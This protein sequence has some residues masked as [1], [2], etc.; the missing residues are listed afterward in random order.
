M[1]RLIL[2][3]LD[4]TVT[5]SGPGIKKSAAIALEAQGIRNYTDEQLDL[6]VGPPL[7]ESFTQTFG[8]TDEQASQAILD[9]RAYYEVK[10]KF[11]NSV[12]DGI[13]VLLKK[14]RESGI[15]C[16]IASSK[17]E[18]FVI[19]ILEYYGIL[20]YFDVIAG[21]TMSEA[22]VEK[23]DIIRLALKRA[24][25]KNLNYDQVWMVGDRRYDV[26]GA[27]ACGIPAV[28]VLY[29]YGSSREL[30]EAGA[31]SI[32]ETVEELGSILLS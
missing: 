9:Y 11:E 5:E 15:L 6:V 7:R 24:D 2:F 16:G 30:E 10:G 12:Y 21:A 19:E 3:D 22:L 31:D 26:A 32:A 8:M 23:P 1:K 4:G 18:R 27:H 17:P 29:G 25:E 28:G 13:P 14:L 20:E